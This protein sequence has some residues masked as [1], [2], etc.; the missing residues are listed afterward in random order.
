MK[1][2]TI[3]RLLGM[4]AL[5]LIAAAPQARAITIQQ[6]FLDNPNVAG[7]V[8]DAVPF[9]DAA[10]VTY[11]NNTLGLGANANGT[12]IGTEEYYTGPTDFSGSVS[13]LDSSTPSEGVATISGWD[14][15]FVKYDGPGGGAVVY[16]LN[17]ASFTI[18][19]NVN[20][21]GAGGITIDGVALN[22]GVSGWT[23][24]GTHQSVP[25]GGS[26]I[27]LLGMSMV[28]VEFLRRKFL[29]A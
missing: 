25:D 8:K 5:M 1:S 7:F 12:V 14:F 11:V 13:L 9:G 19:G 23:A 28:G 10:R 22:G 15:L 24:Y 2:N 21:L 29:N 20:D 17:G 4:G 6:F 16:A 3:T 26:A 27:A 18:A